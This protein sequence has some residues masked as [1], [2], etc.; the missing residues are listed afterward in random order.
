MNMWHSRLFQNL[1]RCLPAF[2]A[3]RPHGPV[4]GIEHHNEVLGA[5]VIDKTDRHGLEIAANPLQDVR[6]RLTLVRVHFETGTDQSLHAHA[7]GPVNL[8]IEASCPDRVSQ[9]K[10][11]HAG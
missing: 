8:P 11:Q 9:L 6:R 2:A 10:L 1:I 4:A 5:T 3:D 7:S